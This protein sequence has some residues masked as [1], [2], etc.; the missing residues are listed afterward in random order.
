LYLLCLIL[1]LNFNKICLACIFELLARPKWSS[2]IF[3]T[4]QRNEIIWGIRNLYNN[5]KLEIN[6]HLPIF[7]PSLKKEFNSMKNA[8]R[9]EFSQR[10]TYIVKK[11]ETT[12]SSISI[13]KECL[14]NNKHLITKEIMWNMDSHKI[15]LSFKHTQ[16]L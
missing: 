2:T 13:P 3:T 11:C 9:I 7:T 14:S 12:K 16:E 1:K 4:K 5:K 6:H 10:G 8:K 15:I